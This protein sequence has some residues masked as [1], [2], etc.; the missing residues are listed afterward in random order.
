MSKRHSLKLSAMLGLLQPETD[1]ELALLQAPEFQIGLDWGEPRFGHPEGKVA[2]HVREVLDN[3]ER[4]SHI[5]PQD[6]RRLRLIT[7]AHDTFKYMEDRSNPRDWSKHHAEIARHFM[8]NYT[9][10]A[11]VLDIIGAHDDAYYAWLNER[12][13]VEHLRHKSLQ[14]LTTRFDHCIQLYYLFFKCD[15]LTGDKTLAPVLWFEEKVNGIRI[16]DL[17]RI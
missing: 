4:L 1:L 6:R 3:I 13:Q 5:S 16:A 15:S 12:K 9:S 17:H 2:Y 8:T 10:D 7:L 11:I 14:A